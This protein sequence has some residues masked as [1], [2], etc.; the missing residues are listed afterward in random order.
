ME[1][2]VQSSN[3]QSL[4]LLLR[5]NKMDDRA[6][7]LQDLLEYVTSM[8]RQS[9]QILDE[10][11]QV[12][13]QLSELKDKQNPVAKTLSNTAHKIE[14]RVSRAREQLRDIRQT[15]EDTAGRMVAGFKRAGVSALR[16]TVTFFGIRKLLDGVQE[17]LGHAARGAQQSVERLEAMG[18]E[19]RAAGS[20][21]HNAGRA[22]AGHERPEV[23]TRPEGRFQAAI[24]TPMR[25]ARHTLTR[26]QSATATAMYSV[27]R[28]EQEVP[29]QGQIYALPAPRQEEA[30]AQAMGGM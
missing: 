30:Q 11:R 28:F 29:A 22:A 3:T 15:I 21:L 27:A 19:L 6:T 2:N 24:L 4:L 17:N 9:K 18:E 26:M 10:L 12:K 13:K 1:Q 25:G 14:A 20:H 8:E 23:I 16:K 7:E 5:E